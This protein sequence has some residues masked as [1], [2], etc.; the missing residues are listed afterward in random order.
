MFRPLA[1]SHRRPHRRGTS[2]ILI[3]VIMLSITAASAVAFALFAMNTHKISGLQADAEGRGGNVAPKV[4]DGTNT[5]NRFFSAIIYDLDDDN[6][7]DL[8]NPLRGHSFAASMYGRVR[9]NTTPWNGVGTFHELT[10]GYRYGVTAPFGL[11]VDRARVVNHT[12]MTFNGAPFMADPE[13]TQH[14]AHGGT[15][16][17]SFLASQTGR[18]YV[19][20]AA[21]YSYPD[22]KD[23]FLA[24]Y[25]PATG[26]ILVPSFHRQAAFGALDPN[27]GGNLSNNWTNA[28]GRLLT[29]RPRPAEHP[30]FPRVP[31][32]YDG[33]F[34]GD[35]QNLPGGVGNGRN[36]SLWMSMGLPTTYI[37]KKR[38]QPLVAPLIVPLNALFDANSHGNTFGG[39]AHRSQAG[40]GPWEVNLGH[41]LSMNEIERQDVIGV[42]NAAPVPTWNGRG[43]RQ[44]RNGQGTRGFAPSSAGR[45]PSYSPVAW[46]STAAGFPAYP[47]ANNTTGVPG[48]VAAGFQDLNESTGAHP[49]LYNPT[50]WPASTAFPPNR[51][52]SVGDVKRFNLRYI[53]TPYWYSESDLAP[54]A[55]TAL[56]GS[57]AGYVHAIGQTTRHGYRLDPAHANRGL[58]A[59]RVYDLDRPKVVPNFVNGAGVG[60]VRGLEYGTGP[61]GAEKT[62]VVAPGAG[63]TIN[64]YPAPQPLAPGAITD[65]A[66]PNAAGA[67]QW[68]SAMARLGSVNVNRP[69]A[70]YRTDLAQPLG[71][72]AAGDPGNVGNAPLADA[73]RQQLA[74]D[75]FTRM[76]AA[77]GASASINLS[78]LNRAN[79]VA[80]TPA[81]PYAITAA[82][83]S[84]QYNALRY[85]AQ[86]AVN[87]VDYTDN[88]DISTVF[89]WNPDPAQANGAN[90]ASAADVGNRVVFGFEKP[91]LVINEA[92]SE[93]VNDPGDNAD[94]PVV[95]GV[96]QPP[97]SPVGAPA[98]HVRFWFELLNPTT[99]NNTTQVNGAVSPIGSGSVNLSGYR[100][101]IRRADRQTGAVAADRDGV[102]TDQQNH[103]YATPANVRGDF[104]QPAGAGGADAV[105]TFPATTVNP[106]NGA[107]RPPAANLPANGFVLVGPPA[108]ARNGNFVPAGGVWQN[109]VESGVPTASPGSA[110]LGY[111]IPLPAASVGINNSEFK[112][113]VVLLRRPANP[114]IAATP[115]GTNPY[116]TTD[117]MDYVPSWDAIN[118]LTADGTDRGPRPAANGF[119]P[120]AE[121]F[122]VGKVQPYAA[123]S[124]AAAPAGVPTSANPY[125]YT[126]PNSMVLRQAPNPAVAGEPQHSFG[127]HNGVTTLAP[128]SGTFVPGAT[129][130]L[131]NVD[132]GGATRTETLMTPFDWLVHMD[133][134]LVNQIELFQVRDTPPHRVTG[135]FLRASTTPLPSGAVTGVTYDAGYANWRSIDDG[136]ARALEYLT[137]KP[138]TVGVAHGGRVPGRINVNGVQDRR[139]LRGLL[140]AQGSNG[141]TPTYVDN[142]A[143]AQ[144]LASRTPVETTVLA[145]GTTP[146]FRARAA[147]GTIIEGFGGDRP[148]MPFGGP[149]AAGNAGAFAYINGGNIDQTILRRPPP[150]APMPAPV[151]VGPHP[152][153]YTDATNNINPAVQYPTSHPNGPDYHRSE[154]VRKMMNN[155]TYV[156]QQYAVFLT[157]GYFEVVGTVATAN[158]QTIPQLG[159]E[160][161]IKVPGDARHQYFAVVDMSQMALDPAAAV[162]TPA[163]VA[164]FFTSLEQ[165]VRP[166]GPAGAGTLALAYS[167]YLGGVLYVGADDAGNPIPISVGSRLVIGYGT[168]EQIVTVRGFPGAGQVSVDGMT[169][170][171]WG[172]ACVSNVR[173]GYPGPQ[174]QFRP[175]DPTSKAVVPYFDK[176]R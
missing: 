83:G 149:A 39:W 111:T 152:Y 9:G 6:I 65:F 167:Q 17:A 8:N 42:S 36:D 24:Q 60:A 5:A 139:V 104:L 90:F 80:N 141:F 168:E 70:D 79:D 95:M 21:G 164:P 135:Q 48:F 170:T 88:D 161:F 89:V 91:R 119:D 165:T 47:L 87:M 121:R 129:P 82:P 72:N 126:F 25:D 18:A 41:G 110:G 4:P 1:R 74:R 30:Q 174:P 11:T 118:R 153:L 107:Y 106:N 43:P 40:F 77:L 3:V 155:I 93:V 2:F 19:S 12:P 158:G 7:D 132:G 102:A 137:V 144:W 163:T 166:A 100:I 50:E 44:Q 28:E 140:D 78:S 136:V 45:L 23:F 71:A 49:A 99:T 128:D 113:H 123:H 56:R 130:T 33:S 176:V 94:G 112:R 76:V 162:P 116:V 51:T 175:T 105:Y 120:I 145:D 160:A 46:N 147:S 151:I 32:N 157:V 86:L 127:Q 15:W 67:H 138:Y 122:A 134:P 114:Y 143:W 159:A 54:V 63:A 52:Y 154:P 20:K 101:E 22:L 156:N 59:T 66:Q 26:Q 146:V 38:V 108:A 109:K 37:G 75:I 27:N 117:M 97:N 62:G 131:T 69:L 92:Y 31:P 171:A 85:L 84:T 13:W 14:R 10:S 53:F 150:P 34:S 96:N 81:G 125:T 64:T 57:A 55:T 148:F 68:Y 169:R 103:L 58:F 16:P 124:F 172:G 61:G 142:T 133:R 173:P 35:V 29:L 73:D 115:T 98:A